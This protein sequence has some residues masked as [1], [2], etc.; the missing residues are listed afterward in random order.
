MLIP[1]HFVS[2]H[3]WGMIAPDGRCKTFD[4]AADGFVRAE[5]CGI[6]VL[7]RLS[8][9]VE[10][11]DRVLAMIRG[12][13][14][15]QD[16]PSS[17][18][19]VPNGLAQQA[20]IRA[21]LRSAR[22]A[23][24]EVGYIEAHGTGT[25]LGDP[26]E[27][28]ALDAVLSSGRDPEHALVV[29]SLKTNVG[30]MEAAAGVGGLIKIVLALQHEQIPAHLHFRRLNS[31]IDLKHLR[32]LVP[33]EPVP[34]PRGTT[35]RIAG[36]SS[37][38]FSGTNAHVVV[39]E[40]P[41][42]EPRPVEEGGGHLV[43]ISART[44][45]ALHAHAR[46]WREAVD[47]RGD[48]PVADMAR[49]STVGRS[50]FAHRAAFLASTRADLCEKLQAVADGRE[51]PGV[52]RGHVDEAG[53]EVAF[54]FTGQG[55]Q[56]AGMG[57]E[58]HRTSPVFRA[59]LE[60][61]D[62]LLRD[63]LERPLLDVIYP[64]VSSG[65]P[66]DETRYTQ[67]AL[68]A[69]EYALY[70][71]WRSWGVT[72]RAVMGHSVGEYVAAHVAG[73]FGLGDALRLVA[74]RGRL[75]QRL[76]AGGAM[77]AIMADEA[78]VGRTIAR[79]AAPVDVAA[80]NG[81]SAVVI[82]GP[83]HAVGSVCAA[84][85]SD[86]IESQP[87][88]VSHAFHSA[89][90]DP[91]IGAFRE[92]AAGMA[93][94]PPTMPLVSNLTG[95]VVPAGTALDADYWSRHVRAAVRFGDGIRALH[96]LPF[97]V[98]LELG[99]SPTLVGMAR[100]SI[101]GADNTWLPS[102]WRGR[103][104]REVMLGSLAALY[105][106]GLDID[107]PA[108]HEGGTA[109]AVSLPTYPFERERYWADG[110]GGTQPRA[111]PVA[112]ASN[113]HPLLG[114]AV[115]AAVRHTI[116][117][118][119]LTASSPA[120]LADH[121]VARQVVFPATGYI[122]MALAAA[123]LHVGADAV[124]DDLVIA[125]PLVLPPDGA[126]V[127]QTVL[128]PAAD[129]SFGV[130]IVAGMPDAPVEQWRVRAAARILPAADD[131]RTPGRVDV[132]QARARLKEVPVAAL[133]DEHAARG[134]E[135]GPAFRRLAHVWTGDGEGLG[136]VNG[137][138][139]EG[140]YVAHPGTLDA[141]LQVVGAAVSKGQGEWS[142][143][144]LPTGISR[145]RFEGGG[146]IA[147]SH[148]RVHMGSAPGD[149][150]FLAD[151][152]LFD[153][154]E[155]QVMTLTGMRFRRATAEALTRAA[156]RAT[157]EWLYELRWSAMDVAPADRNEAKGPWA[158]VGGG[159]LGAELAVRLTE[160]GG[161]VT[162]VTAD[163]VDDVASLVRQAPAGHVRIV[164]MGALETSGSDPSTSEGGTRAI[165]APVLALVQALAALP[166]QPA[167]RVV[168]VT[169]RARQLDD[170]P[171]NALQAMVWPLAR[172]VSA[173]HPQLNCQCIDV[174]AAIDM[175]RDVF[176]SVLL[177]E[178][179]EA[180]VAIRDD[181]ARAARLGPSPARSDRSGSGCLALEPTPRRVLDGLRLQPVP[182]RVPGPGEIEIRVTHAGLNFRDVL[183]A[184]GMYPGPAGP[185]GAECVGIVAAVGS[186]DV[187]GLTAGDAVL[188][189][190]GGSLR[191]FVTTDARLVVRCPAGL[192]PVDAA[193][194]PVTFLTAAYGLETLAQLRRGERVLIHAGTGGVGLAAIQVARRAGAEIYATAGSPEKRA[195][196]TALGVPHV[197]NSRS[198]SFADAIRT[199][200]GGR[201]VD[202]VLNSL[203]GDFIAASAGILAPGGR[204][205]ELGKTGIWSAEEMR[206]VQPDAQY[207]PVYL[208]DVD[209]PIIHALLT[210]IVDDVM[211]GTLQALPARVYPLAA[212]AQGFRYMAQAR[213]I[214]KIV[215]TAPEVAAQ[216]KPDASYLIT[217][218]LGAL[219]LTVA[220][221]LAARGARSLVLA[222]RTPAKPEASASLDALRAAGVTVTVAAADVSRREDVAGLIA[223][224][225]PA[226]P[227]RGV[228]HAAGIVSDAMVDR[229]TWAQC[230][231]VFAP[232]VQ[233]AWYLHAETAA[234]P[235]DFFVLFS[236]AAA[237]LP[238]PG[239]ANYAA[240]NA[241][242]D[243]L[244]AD[245]YA[246]GLP[247]LSIAWGPWEGGGM[248]AALE[249]GSRE[250]WSR[251]GL[252]AIPAAQGLALLEQLMGAPIA[253]AGVLP[254]DW[255]R[256][257]D[258]HPGGRVPR[259]ISDLV[260][261][262]APG[263]LRGRA[264][265][266]A[267]QARVDRAPAKG[268]H[269]VVHA[270]V[271][272]VVRQVLGVAPSFVLESSQGLRAMG[273]DSLMAVE[274]RNHLQAG[275]GRPL[276]STIAF[277][278]PSIGALVSY[279]A[280]LVDADRA[281]VASE[282]G[283]GESPSA[284]GEDLVGLSD[285]EMEALLARELE[286]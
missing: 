136:R 165:A 273:M 76:P 20:V 158:I 199:E 3:K 15:N 162:A 262:S 244:A 212:A 221:A 207:F 283:I 108:V 121:Q 12:S 84:L 134:I 67:P 117:E 102:L 75:M 30:H 180:G 130:E 203:A 140:V 85:Q 170:E 195:Y 22:V 37:F 229:L 26:I 248:A 141:C 118:Q 127:V 53:T 64:A 201:G 187:G 226:R 148:V 181:K 271:R 156:R 18:L 91:M 143:A 249:E 146:P 1:D 220:R 277:E 233:G 252:G 260:R 251:L 17:G 86:G 263:P 119:T 34:W 111:V 31:S 182:R 214:G 4:E 230:E 157:D 151:V 101:S 100:R 40:A 62:A 132:A 159:S 204:F 145:I 254:I 232:K 39:E 175:A 205:V 200:T 69:L 202:V 98:F 215:F 282:R 94:E 255:Q 144:Y 171:V 38:G 70:R 16:G 124:L 227:L 68:F 90:M 225:D 209:P 155:T 77:A 256:F 270:Y 235:L 48:L 228:I 259:L 211:A 210:R 241:Y 125:E 247:A 174:G 196:L 190:V 142:D 35:R 240:A 28:E 279:L 42:E 281:D 93:F 274:L 161:T 81:P 54:L 197:F 24:S 267:L 147:W 8:D 239:Q 92:V 9:A 253:H 138:E 216:V 243:A 177:A 286:Q 275:V 72:P 83:Q 21:A 194:L 109:R 222:S 10:N 139:E 71:L 87:L 27:L 19:T 82:A 74:A 269:A 2:F 264:E 43:A 245:R 206:S 79:L 276:P 123:R 112:A 169:E 122:E 126:M 106:K 178:P 32:V 258:S 208:G 152:S 113:V 36:V 59:A 213:H 280:P 33:S 218:G 168:L 265:R 272:E 268:R 66:I 13:A 179:I 250:R 103:N 61:C 191:T 167:V 149:D 173:E 219:G 176:L 107:W 234:L 97:R 257:A 51:M 237:L 89:L 58:L 236:S 29:G 114:H 184:L 96:E 65:G 137:S 166:D 6:V 128:S 278:H 192:S 104:D 183:N 49:A 23:P 246:A 95:A 193:T 131:P 266:P 129:G 45:A 47:G 284:T 50:H 172:S 46:R 115:R 105:A 186:G 55:S 78:I 44:P 217:G 163:A 285:A 88:V 133:Y 189:M 14:V 41:A 160:A 164:H 56:Y 52:A 5:G 261:S 150:G 153:E 99:P 110:L 11:G 223:A 7:K 242:L 73:V 120:L 185:L 198:L 63:E 188:G 135:Y 154:A 25:S 231:E 116:F 60:E 224:I 57:R 80:V 238:T